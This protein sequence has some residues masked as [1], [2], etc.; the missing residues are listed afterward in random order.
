MY[1]LSDTKHMPGHLLHNET[2]DQRTQNGAQLTINV[3]M[4][5]PSLYVTLFSLLTT[6]ALEND[7]VI[8]SLNLDLGGPHLCLLS[9]LPF[10]A[11]LAKWAPALGLL[12]VCVC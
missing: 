1:K 9:F 5:T 3:A 6:M 2:S 12:A 11:I 8:D 7:D 4:M 10:L